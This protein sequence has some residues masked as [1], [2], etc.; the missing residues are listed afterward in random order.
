MSCFNDM[1]C[2][3]DSMRRALP[4]IRFLVWVVLIWPSLQM[5]GAG[6]ALAVDDPAADLKETVLPNGL[7]VLTLE[8]HSTPVVSFQMWVRVGSK[9][10]TFY[11]G[12]AHLI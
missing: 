11:T 2:F 5:L 6:M 3:H 12:I 8:D 4:G 7:T 10:E 9:D 1:S